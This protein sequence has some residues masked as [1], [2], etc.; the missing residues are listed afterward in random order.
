MLSTSSVARQKKF[1]KGL[2]DLRK[3]TKESIWQQ[4]RDEEHVH[5]YGVIEKTGNGGEGVQRCMTCGFELE[6]EEL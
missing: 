2:H 6:V 4:R 1:E 5:E 3:R